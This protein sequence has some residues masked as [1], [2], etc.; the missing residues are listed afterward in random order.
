[1]RYK[2]F[3]PGE[4]VMTI[5][6]HEGIPSGTAGRVL[7]RWKGM[8]YVVRLP[9][10]TFE[11]INSSEF[12]SMTPD[13]HYLREGDFGV[14]TSNGHH[15]DFAKV[16]DIFQVVKVVENV[17]YYEIMFDDELRMF[18]GFRLAPYIPLESH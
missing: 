6:E 18:G 7:S 15:H 14:V 4:M 11:W 13:R 2:E 8:A 12:G 1:V 16:G 17:D 5:D 10:G 9:D 3:R